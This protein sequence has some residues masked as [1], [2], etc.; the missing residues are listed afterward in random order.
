MSDH[1]INRINSNQTNETI[2]NS[3]S[4][5]QTQSIASQNSANSQTSQKL[6]D[7]ELKYDDQRKLAKLLGEENEQWYSSALSSK[8][9]IGTFRQDRNT[10]TE[11]EIVDLKELISTARM[12]D[13]TTDEI[14]SK[15]DVVNESIKDYYQQQISKKSSEIYARVNVALEKMEQVYREEIGHIRRAKRQELDNAIGK[16]REEYETYYEA[17]LRKRLKE[18]P[19]LGA[20]AAGDSLALE[21]S[22][23]EADWREKL[24]FVMA[25]NA[26]LREQLEFN[27]TPQV[28]VD[29]SAADKANA[30]NKKLQG[31][32]GK[33]QADLENTK[34]ELVQ[35][36]RD[37]ERFEAAKRQ[38]QQQVKAEQE[39]NKKLQN[40]IREM[41][42]KIQDLGEEHKK[43]ISKLKK[44]HSSEISKLNSEWETRM[45]SQADE[46][47]KKIT[48]TKERALAQITSLEIELTN[49]QN[50]AQAMNSKL[51]KMNKNL[52]SMHDEKEK[53]NAMAKKAEADAHATT[54]S[55][56]S[57]DLRAANQRIAE[58]EK[59]LEKS[60]RE[61][62]KMNRNWEKRFRILRAS[63]HEIKNESFVRRRLE[64][65]PMALH[66][67]KMNY[68]SHSQMA[69][70]PNFP[71]RDLPRKEPPKPLSPLKQIQALQNSDQLDSTR[72]NSAAGSD[73][74]SSDDERE[75]M[76]R[77]TTHGEGQ[78][79][80]SEDQLQSDQVKFIVRQQP[81]NPS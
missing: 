15:Q 23:H 21:G 22:M 42:K 41:E 75:V 26:Q 70:S 7:S 25:E 56:D 63:M 16:L 31:E 66:T 3:Q 68:R 60:R 20:P 13:K 48:E 17:E 59:S 14:I 33:M 55:G 8:L 9:T 64:Y 73:R 27:Q 74:F 4:M 29:T 61:I 10:Q 6:L 80:S 72:P 78:Q 1:S 46:Y 67:A 2:S 58:L 19:K 39:Q 50:Q 32:M 76:S 71:M 40:Q 30:Q 38:L 28:I 5:A 49:A 24:E 51:S 77:Q 81:P 79:A 53:A 37:L 62:E 18:V 47:E 69:A 36:K 35:A 57:N 54:V 12:L 43:E 65:Q 45:K 34:K 11:S 44:E 52:A